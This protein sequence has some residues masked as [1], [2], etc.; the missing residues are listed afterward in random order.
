MR[1]S[2]GQKCLAYRGA[3]VWNDL[4]SETKLASN[5]QGFKSRLKTTW[6]SNAG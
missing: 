3:K 6:A 1:S 2:N 5:I 4:D